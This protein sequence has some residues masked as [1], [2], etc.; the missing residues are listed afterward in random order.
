MRRG[1][2]SAKRNRLASFALH[3]VREDMNQGRVKMLPV[4]A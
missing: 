1:E 3:T 2:A 4:K